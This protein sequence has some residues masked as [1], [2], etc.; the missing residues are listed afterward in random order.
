M[1]KIMPTRMPY[2]CPFRKAAIDHRP[3]VAG[4]STSAIRI[5]RPKPASQ[6]VIPELS[7]DEVSRGGTRP[8][9]MARTI[10]P[11]HMMD[12]HNLPGGRV[13]ERTI[14]HS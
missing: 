13:A 8:Q 11:L 12:S 5:A 3:K 6:D 2:I 1:P 10:P 14:V 7:G 9:R 4:S